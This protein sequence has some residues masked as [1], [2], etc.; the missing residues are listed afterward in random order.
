M[1]VATHRFVSVHLG[2]LNP[3]PSLGCSQEH[4]PSSFPASSSVHSV[5]SSEHHGCIIQTSLVRKSH[6]DFEASR[7]FNIAFSRLVRFRTIQPRCLG[8]YLQSTCIESHIFCR[9]GPGSIRKTH[10]SV[11]WRPGG[12]ATHTHACIPNDFNIPSCRVSRDCSAS[13]CAFTPEHMREVEESRP[14]MGRG[15]ICNLQACK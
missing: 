3:I 14:P 7:H 5:P 4:L 9:G 2:L 12:N 8:N 10:V 1:T 6:L 13:D 11:V 15:G